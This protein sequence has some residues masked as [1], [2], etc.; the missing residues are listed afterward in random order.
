MTLRTH[1]SKH[2]CDTHHGSMASSDLGA[3]CPGPCQETAPLPTLL[4]PPRDQEHTCRPRGHTHPRTSLRGH[5]QTC[6]ASDTLK[7]DPS[8]SPFP[9]DAWLPISVTWEPP[10]VGDHQEDTLSVRIQT[11]WPPCGKCLRLGQGLRR[12]G[13]GWLEIPAQ[14]LAWW[15]ACTAELSRRLRVSN[16][17][18]S[19]PTVT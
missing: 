2:C 5:P 3:I 12:A 19:W 9:P 10:D 14:G 18:C 13:L 1:P 11:P 8:T 16:C 4:L 6:P 15:A 7:P 17:L